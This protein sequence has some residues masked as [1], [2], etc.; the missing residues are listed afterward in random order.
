MTSLLQSYFFW[1]NGG[2]GKGPHTGLIETRVSNIR[3][4]LLP[5]DRLFRRT[6][7]D[8]IIVEDECVR[9]AAHLAALIPTAANARQIAEGMAQTNDLLK[10]LLQK[11]NIQDIIETFP[12]LLSY[13]GEMIIQAFDRIQANI[14][15]AGDLK[16]LLRVGLLFDTTSWNMVEDDFVR[17]ALRLMKKLS[18]KGIKRTIIMENASMEEITA[19]PL[20]RWTKYTQ[21][22]IGFDEKLAVKQS[23]ATVVGPLIICVADRYKQGNMYVVFNQNV[24]P[25]GD[26]S[27]RAIEILFKSFAV[28]GLKV[29]MLLRKLNDMISVNV[30][31]TKHYSKCKSVTELTVRY[32]EFLNNSTVE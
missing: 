27:T 16:T 11:N 22:D 8:I 14:Y 15:V 12:H 25:C 18:N 2:L 10:L 3:K 13:E 9:H 4:D 1:H 24:I 20:I 7:K 26:S 28:L 30:W 32:K 5:E 31:G 23:S 17:G 6:K 21:T 19:A 29:P